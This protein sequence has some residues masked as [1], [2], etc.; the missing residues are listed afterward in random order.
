MFLLAGQK[1]RKLATSYTVP[2]G[3]EAPLQRFGPS[4]LY[5]ATTDRQIDNTVNILKSSLVDEKISLFRGY[6]L[7]ILI[8]YILFS[9]IYLKTLLFPKDFMMY[10]LLDIKTIR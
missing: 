10:K 9:K 3:P 7:D 2:R 5:S 4:S 1:I 6:V 8:Q